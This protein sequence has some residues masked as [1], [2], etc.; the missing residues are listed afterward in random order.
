MKAEFSTVESLHCPLSMHHRYYDITG[1]MPYFNFWIEAPTFP[2][3]F[4]RNEGIVI[5]NIMKNF[6]EDN[7][8]GES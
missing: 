6:L 1:N 4:F 8:G 2:E 3:M 7:Y 5:Y